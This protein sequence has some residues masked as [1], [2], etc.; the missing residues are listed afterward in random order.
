MFLSSHEPSF[1]VFLWFP[2]HTNCSKTWEIVAFDKED[3]T[4]GRTILRH[5][6]FSFHGLDL[7]YG[8]PYLVCWTEYIV[9][10]LWKWVPNLMATA[11]VVCLHIQN[12]W[13]IP[14]S[15]KFLPNLVCIIEHVVLICSK[16]DQ[17]RDGVR[18]AVLLKVL[19][20]PHHNW[21]KLFFLV[22]SD[23][24]PIWVDHCLV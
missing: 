7:E 3:F 8:S 13:S 6:R 20:D 21:V 5:S 9:T 17:D 16:V 14:F 10:H 4:C 15:L 22:M 24:R 2:L 18:E 11:S 12:K 23:F 1:V 19:D